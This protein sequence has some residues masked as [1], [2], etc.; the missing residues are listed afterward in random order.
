[1]T[2]TVDCCGMRGAWKSHWVAVQALVR[3][4]NLVSVLVLGGSDGANRHF[5]TDCEVKTD[6]AR[7]RSLEVT[8]WSLLRWAVDLD[9][10]LCSALTRK[11]VQSEEPSRTS[12]VSGWDFVFGVHHMVSCKID[13]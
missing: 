3:W 7:V 13:Q 2:V 8:S 1:M 11:Q 5:L 9:E 10:Y 12:P 4:P 6:G